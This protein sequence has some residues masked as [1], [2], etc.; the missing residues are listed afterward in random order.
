LVLDFFSF[1]DF[2]DFL[3]I[4]GDAAFVTFESATSTPCGFLH[5][6]YLNPSS[7]G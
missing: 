6:K 1:F 2:F 3:A 7:V 4:G 5:L